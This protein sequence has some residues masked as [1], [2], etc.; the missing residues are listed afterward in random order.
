MRMKLKI[1]IVLKDLHISGKILQ[2]ENKQIRGKGI[3]LSKTLLPLEVVKNGSIN[4]NAKGGRRDTL[5]NPSTEL[6]WETNRLEH[7][8]Q[9]FSG[10][11]IISLVKLV[12]FQKASERR[13]LAGIFVQNL[14]NK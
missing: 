8:L 11:G 1:D 2:T 4:R 6:G 3:P 7:P 13:P 12:K 10:N 5:H 9:E 14:L